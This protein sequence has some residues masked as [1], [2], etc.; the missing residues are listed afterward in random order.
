MKNTIKPLFILVVLLCMYSCKKDQTHEVITVSEELQIK[1]LNEHSYIHTSYLNTESFGKV[2]C[3]GMIIIDNNEALIFDTPTNDSVSGALINW[4]QKNLKSEVKGVVATHFHDD[5]LGGLKEFHK[6][7]ISSYASNKTIR[8][9]KNK[10]YTIPQ[11]GFD[12]RLELKVGNRE[13]FNTFHGE[14]H[15][16]D[17]VISYFPDEKVLF[18]GCLIKSKGA[19]K[20]YLGDANTEEWSTTVSKIKEKY[21]KV[22]IVIPGH[23]AHGGQELLEYTISLFKTE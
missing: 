5:C 7:K 10:N 6:R 1:K 18:G 23:G 16:S 15:T 19:K 3:N 17:N 13:V 21:P 2:P 9:A 20:G 12:T 8:L 14:G 22:E 4:I 11:N